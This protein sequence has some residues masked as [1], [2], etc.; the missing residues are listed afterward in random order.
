MTSTKGEPYRP[1]TSEGATWSTMA[2]IDRSAVTHAV[3]RLP[4]VR[5]LLSGSRA[6]LA[7]F[8]IDTRGRRR[9]YSCTLWKGDL[10][11]GFEIEDGTGEMTHSVLSE[12][13]GALAPLARDL[14]ARWPDRARPARI[15][16]ATDGH[17][18]IF[19]AGHPSCA[20]PE[21]MSQHLSGH[22]PLTLIA[23][24]GTD[25]LLETIC[26]MEREKE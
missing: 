8:H 9:K 16:V 4:L 22:A 20:G 12:I 2:G 13:C 23:D 18:V 15:G 10:E 14:A 11:N 1:S 19:N 5:A 3:Q 21:W 17:R 26:P 24:D 25:G 6:Q 7:C